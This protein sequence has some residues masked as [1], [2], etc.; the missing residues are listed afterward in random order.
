MLG[1]KIMQGEGKEMDEELVE[2]EKSAPKHPG[3]TDCG[4][5]ASG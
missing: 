5:E 1:K 3:K 4:T 2:V